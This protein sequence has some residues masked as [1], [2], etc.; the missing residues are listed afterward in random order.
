M[1]QTDQ[2]L[3]ADVWEDYGRHFLYAC[4]DEAADEALHPETVLTPRL[5]VRALERRSGQAGWSVVLTVDG[6]GARFGVSPPA[7][8]YIGNGDLVV[9]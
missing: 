9:T 7:L 3:I 4:E 6:Q 5:L 2:E 8:R 1:N